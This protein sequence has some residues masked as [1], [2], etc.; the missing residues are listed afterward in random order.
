MM[1]VGGGGADR[2][3]VVAQQVD[4]SR[5]GCGVQLRLIEGDGL[6]HHEAHQ[7]GLGADR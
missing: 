5:C 1:L 4:A 3:V 7:S 6:V 2:V